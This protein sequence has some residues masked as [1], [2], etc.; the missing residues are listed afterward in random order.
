MI[1]LQLYIAAYPYEYSLELREN[2][3]FTQFFIKVEELEVFIR[4][5][6]GHIQAIF[7]ELII[8]Q[9][10]LLLWRDYLVRDID[11]FF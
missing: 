1:L 8:L 5:L 9:Q 6:I 7:S 4:L 11:R 2:Y 10:N 3:L